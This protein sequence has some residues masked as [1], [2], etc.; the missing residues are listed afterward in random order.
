MR[1][2]LRGPAAWYVFENLEA[3]RLAVW[4]VSLE[5]LL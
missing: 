2:A 4:L 5:L 3:T 1:V